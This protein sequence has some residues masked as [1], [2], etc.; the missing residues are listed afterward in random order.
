[1]FGLFKGTEEKIVESICRQSQTLVG[2]MGKDIGYLR[3]KYSNKL[4]IISTILGAAMV[5]HANALV[6]ER[7]EGKYPKVFTLLANQLGSV[8]AMVKACIAAHQGNHNYDEEM[9]YYKRSLFVC[10]EW[11]GETLKNNGV[12]DQTI[13]QIIETYEPSIRSMGNHT[14]KLLEG[15]NLW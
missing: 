13:S 7:T 11:V 6:F 15:L 4:S 12:D 1:M 3:G 2:S 9:N 14:R 10:L 5:A 8:Y